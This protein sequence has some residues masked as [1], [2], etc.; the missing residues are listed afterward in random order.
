M[1]SIQTAIQLTDRMTAPLQ[2]ITNALN[3][4]ISN[5]ERLDRV[6]DSAMDASNF[7]GVREEINR[8]NQAMEELASNTEQAGAKTEGLLGI[9]K[10]LASAY[11][12]K[13]AV[14]MSDTMV[15]TEARINMINDGLQSTDELMDMIRASAERSR[16]SFTDTADVVAK[17][18]QRAGDVFSSNAETIQFAENLNKMFVIA[19]ASQAEMSSASLQLTQA[20]GSGVLR[21]EELNAMLESAPN[22]IQ[23]IAD[24][25]NVPVGSI[26]DLASEGKITAD[27]VKNAL[28]SATG[29][30]DAQF[31][32]MPM[33]WGQVI[34]GVMN[35]IIQYSQPLLDFISFL[36]QNWSILEPIVLGVAGAIAVYLA[37]TKGAELA[38]KAWTAVQTVFNAVMAMNPV[39]LIIMA[40]MVLI[41]LLYSVVAIINKVTGSSISATGIITGAIN[42]AIAFVWNLFLGLLDLVLG[43]INYWTNKFSIFVNFFSNVFKNPISSVIYL[44]QGLADNV[45]GVVEKI[46]S[47]LDF[48]FGSNMAG[49]IAEWRSGLK[50]MADDMVEKYAP[51][52]NYEKVM[53][54]TDLSVE[55]L[56]LERYAY[57]DAWKDGYAFGEGFGDTLD[58]KFD[59]DKFSGMPDDVSD[60]KE[61]LDISNEE[62]K[63]MKDLAEQ[64]AINRFT[65]AEIKIDMTNNN[66]VNNSN[67]LD[68]IINGLTEKLYE[69]MEIVAEGV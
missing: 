32:Q 50:Q 52:E 11:V 64:E 48:V 39:V 57:G 1:A 66:T 4:T 25:M 60:I 49:T 16:A 24:Y 17:L 2:H 43:I 20:L 62:L 67:D 23:T 46:A 19:G 31:Q 21:G 14:E 42:T 18:G 54:G 61:S 40:V 44:F 26:R 37:V 68:G 55:S 34:T 10:K 28:L 6:S 22:V 15:Q 56:G 29:E 35:K 53:N 38:T 51:N 59:Y 5:F 45:L 3:M 8:A 65:T 27:I 41:G 36:A 58:D 12:I 7:V 9:A 30:I 69:S 33:T 47:A 13:E 63:Y